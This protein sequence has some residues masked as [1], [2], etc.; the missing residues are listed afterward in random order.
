ML[1]H[2]ILLT[3]RCFICF[4]IP[5]VIHALS[6]GSLRIRHS[7]DGREVAGERMSKLLEIR[8]HWNKH[9]YSDLKNRWSAKERG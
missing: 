4:S 1:F 2:E 9:G 3:R 6:L 5:L 8:Q 7:L